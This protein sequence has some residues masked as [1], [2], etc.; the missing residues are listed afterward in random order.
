MLL[1]G[2]VLE[3]LRFVRHERQRALGRNRFPHDVV[4]RDGDRARA[5]S[6]NADEA[7]ECRGLARAVR[8]DEADD[9]AGRDVERQIVD[10]CHAAVHLGEP[11]D[12]NHREGPR[13][14]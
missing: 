6:V 11:A 8:A 9:L 10:G 3:Q 1:H 5:R 2:E 14:Y 4:P 12:L 13:C 7:A